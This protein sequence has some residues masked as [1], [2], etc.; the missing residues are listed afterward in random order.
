MPILGVIASSILK[1][2]STFDSI[3]TQT[4]TSGGPTTLSFTSIPQGYKH[5]QIRW[6]G[7]VG[8]DGTTYS[9]RFNSDT[10][11]NYSSYL[12]YGQNGSVAALGT[13]VGNSAMYFYG[14]GR[15]Y[16]GTFSAGILD[17]HDYSLTTKNKTIRGYCG[18]DTN[19]AGDFGDI[20]VATSAVWASNS[21]ITTIDISG[22]SA[23]WQNGTQFA[24]YGIKG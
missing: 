16:N 24:L 13:A 6:L 2:T 7:R 19:S 4:V 8:T 21:A 12:Y 9:M 5:L 1:S 10:G 18:N 20:Y 23:A 3:A 15:G 11:N 17:I 14:W 22:S